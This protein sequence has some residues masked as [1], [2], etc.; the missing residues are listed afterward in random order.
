MSDLSNLKVG[1]SIFVVRHLSRF[2]EKEPV[3]STEIITKVGRK[4]GYYGTQYHEKA[5][6]LDSGAS[7]HPM[8][9]NARVNGLGF[10][11]YRSE[12]DYFEQVLQD[13]R[14]RSLSERLIRCNGRLTTLDPVIVEAIHDILDVA[15]IVDG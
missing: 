9:D 6:Y 2:S 7:Y 11:V 12:V 4:Y 8:D 3:T 14:F 1:D 5:F 13:A 15:D 10:D